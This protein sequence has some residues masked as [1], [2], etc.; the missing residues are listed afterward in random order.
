[1]TIHTTE[2]GEYYKTLKGNSDFIYSLTFST[3]NALLASASGDGIITLWNIP[4]GRTHKILR[5]HS[6][7]C[8]S[9]DFSTD[10]ILLVSASDDG[11]IKLWNII[12][13]TL[14]HWSCSVAFLSC[15]TN[16]ISVSSDWN[17]VYIWDMATG[18]CQQTMHRR[19]RVITSVACSADGT[20]LAL[21]SHEGIIEL[22]DMAAR[23]CDQTLQVNKSLYTLSFDMTNSKLY[24]NLGTIPLHLQTS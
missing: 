8:S 19:T 3:H 6:R 4:T 18:Q 9:M 23:R 12:R 16:I 14:G 2:T 17:V 20:M 1:M 10:S 13:G 7:S 21:A 22:T 11:T 5:G 24:T 15:G